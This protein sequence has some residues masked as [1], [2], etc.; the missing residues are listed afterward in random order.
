MDA[1]AH[2]L[3]LK[4]RAAS[5]HV[6]KAP[7]QAPVPI[8]KIIQFYSGRNDVRIDPSYTANDTGAAGMSANDAGWISLAPGVYKALASWNV[9]KPSAQA[10]QALNT[11][12]H[13]A[14][15]MRRDGP[16][17]TPNDWTDPTRYQSPTGFRPW[18]D[19]HQA[20]ALSGQLIPDALQRF[21]GV[22]YDSALGQQYA[23]LGQDAVR[24]QYGA[25]PKDPFG[26][27]T[28][29][30]QDSLKSIGQLGPGFT[31]SF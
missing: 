8:A 1:L 2:A 6:Q 9:Q 27:P 3:A 24:Y 14:L 11:V 4:A 21:F 17:H 16:W 28:Q 29:Q 13:E 20:A 5:A 25:N 7:A 31:R 12:I 18:D 10:V 23:K 15:H 26:A 19:E 22:K 30:W